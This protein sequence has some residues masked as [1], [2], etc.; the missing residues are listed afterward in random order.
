[1]KP[2][3]GKKASTLSSARKKS[4]SVLGAS[5]DPGVL[6]RDLISSYHIMESPILKETTGGEFRVYRASIRQSIRYIDLL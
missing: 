5:R 2:L 3:R 1:M 6:F 4:L